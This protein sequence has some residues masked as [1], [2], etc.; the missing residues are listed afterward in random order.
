VHEIDLNSATKAGAGIRLGKQIKAPVFQTLTSQKLICKTHGI[1]P[2]GR[3]HHEPLI[4]SEMFKIFL[5]I[6]MALSC[7]AHKHNNNCQH[8]GTVTTLED[9][10][11]DKG[12]SPPPPPPPPH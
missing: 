2:P 9:T 8:S 1:V 10:G 6:F 3:Q 5:A 12:Q 4:F 11:G 7:P